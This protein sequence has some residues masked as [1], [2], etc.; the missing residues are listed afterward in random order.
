M[1]K[2]DKC[3][4]KTLINYCLKMVILE[5]KQALLIARA[6]VCLVVIKM[7]MFICLVLFYV[8]KVRA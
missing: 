6:L 8:P 4:G 5:S 2:L 1:E 7:K 3:V